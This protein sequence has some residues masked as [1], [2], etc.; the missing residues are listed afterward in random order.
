MDDGYIEGL[1]VAQEPGLE[2]IKATEGAK[3][4]DQVHQPA[5]WIKDIQESTTT[6]DLTMSS[7]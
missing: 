4:I 6:Q 2:D 7:D 3:A 1:G 5:L